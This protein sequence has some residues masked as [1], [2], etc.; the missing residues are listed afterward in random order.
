MKKALA[1]LGDGYHAVA[2]LHLTIVKELQNREYDVPLNKS[3]DFNLIVISRY[4]FDDVQRFS[5]PDLPSNND[6][7]LTRKQEEQFSEYVEDGGNILI[8]HGGFA[9]YRK[10]GGLSKLA[11][12]HCINHPPISSIKIKPIN[13]FDEL[14]KALS[15]MKILM[16]N[17]KLRWM[18][19][20]QM[21]F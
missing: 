8:Y 4:A 3:S 16:K 12:S 5:Q 1:I 7:W 19:Q 6:R 11:K 9:F 13:G 21:S 20:K 18:K 17:I 15:L 10:D 2:P 14:A